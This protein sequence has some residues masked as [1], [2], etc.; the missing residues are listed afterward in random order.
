MMVGQE[1]YGWEWW[2]GDYS[3][4]AP[5]TVQVKNRDVF[6]EV[7]LTG[8]Q[9][10]WKQEDDFHIWLTKVIGITQ[11]VSES[12]IE[13]F[14]IDHYRQAVFRKNVTSVTVQLQVE[15]G[16]ARGRLFINYWE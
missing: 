14:G 15:N 16:G 12:G 5:L 13:D 10:S 8:R 4:S 2:S 1:A 11:I 6:A 7:A 3:V 9:H